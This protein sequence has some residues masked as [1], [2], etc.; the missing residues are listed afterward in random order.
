M[1]DGCNIYEIRSWTISDFPAY[2]I[3]SGWTTHGRLSCPIC[4]GST[5]AFQLKNGR[6]SCWFDCHRRFLPI[7]HPYRRNKTLFR[8]KKVVRDSPPPYLTG[9]QILAEIDYYGALETVPRGGNWHVQGNMS[10]GYGV[11]HNWH[12]KSIFWELPYWK[13][14]L[15]CHNLDVM[16]IEKNFFDN[17]MNT[18]L[19]VPGKTEDTPKSQGWT[20]LLSAGEVSYISRAMA[21][22]LFPSSGCHQQRKQLCWI[23][24]HQKLSSLMVM[25]QICQDVLNVVKSFP[26]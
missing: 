4:R 22:F 17:I 21:V 14:L 24:S 10:D 7:S 9:Q 1:A 16:H 3:L 18:I 20:Y 25:F 12:K 26:E 5:D 2:G 11:S 19:N 15:L 8:Y 23:G 6:K 13:D